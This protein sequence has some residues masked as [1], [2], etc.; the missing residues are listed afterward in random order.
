MKD[1]DEHQYQPQ[2][3]QR[4]NGGARDESHLDP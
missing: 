1:N 3:E 4:A 2:H